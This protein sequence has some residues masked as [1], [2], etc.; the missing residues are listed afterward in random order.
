MNIIFKSNLPIQS[1]L[2]EE[3]THLDITEII[4]DSINKVLNPRL[5]RE[6]LDGFIKNYGISIVIDTSSSCLN[7]LSMSININK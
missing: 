2:E 1:V 3:G 6:V 4:K 7:E 5:Y